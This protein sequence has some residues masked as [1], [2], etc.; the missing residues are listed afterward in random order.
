MIYFSRPLLC[1]FMLL[2][3]ACLPAQAAIVKK[4]ANIAFE[5]RTAAWDAVQQFPATTSDS[6]AVTVRTPPASILEAYLE[7]PE[8]NYVRGENRVLSWWDQLRN[9]FFDWLSDVFEENG[10]N[11]IWEFIYYAIALVIFGYAILSFLKMDARSLFSARKRSTRKVFAETK[12]DLHEKDFLSLA[13]NALQQNDLQLSLR[14]YYMYVLKMLDEREVILWSPR[15]TNQ[16]YLRECRLPELM[17]AF[18]R[19]TYLFD[20]SWYGDFPVDRSMVEEAQS[21][22]LNLVLEPGGMS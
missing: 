10:Q 5:I 3:L 14:M 20:H 12:E 21:L 11:D 15:K 18:A 2:P 8:Y 22:A 6:T 19:L 9:W 4:D 16:D 7:N 13:E 1:F 17:P